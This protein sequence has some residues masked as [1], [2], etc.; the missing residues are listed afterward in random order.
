M[1]IEKT[2]NSVKFLLIKT[3]NEGEE[4]VIDSLRN[5]RF[6]LPKISN[7]E[8][9]LKIEEKTNRIAEIDEKIASYA[10]YAKSMKNAIKTCEKEIEFEVYATGM[11]DE[12]VS[13]DGNVSI[14]YIKYLENKVEE[15]KAEKERILDTAE[16]LTNAWEE[17]KRTCRSSLDKTFKTYQKSGR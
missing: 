11:A 8:I 17:L 3:G 10:G 6:E 4:E 14:A 9:T 12:S 1:S 5:Y 7:Q 15:L 2:K 16:E 13:S